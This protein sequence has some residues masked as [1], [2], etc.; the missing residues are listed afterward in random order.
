M[1]PAKLADIQARLAG[2]PLAAQADILD[3]IAEVTRLRNAMHQ[4][5]ALASSRQ[6]VWVHSQN[7]AELRLLALQEIEAALKETP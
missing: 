3:L 4:A 1:T 6:V 7:L 5:I 2:Y